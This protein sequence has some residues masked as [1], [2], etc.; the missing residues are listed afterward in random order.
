MLVQKTKTGKMKQKVYILILLVFS[1]T[2]AVAQLAAGVIASSA[3][4]TVKNIY[5]D[6][7]LAVS[8]SNNSG[9]ITWDASKEL[10]VRRYEVQKSADGENF[11]Y[12]TAVPAMNQSYSINDNNL[13]GNASYYRIKIVDCEGNYF[14]SKTVMLDAQS[15][16]EQVRMLPTQIGQTVF[17]WMPS[18]TNISKAVISDAAG[19]TLLNNAGVSNTSN[20]AAI[21]TANIPAG[22]YHINLQT[23]KGE[24]IKLKFNK[25]S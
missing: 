14:Y 21:E 16:A 11:N 6:L 22:V 18:N 17:V 24:T 12:V 13:L 15:S 4:S 8:L 1:T 9:Q 3:V 7:H 2:A 25:Q 23:N 20:I 19:R 5:A 10:K